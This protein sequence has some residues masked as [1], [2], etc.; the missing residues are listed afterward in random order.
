MVAALCFSYG[1]GP[2]VHE[3]RPE[4]MS[5][6]RRP[7]NDPIMAPAIAVTSSSS[8]INSG[9][10]DRRSPA[11]SLV[12]DGPDLGDAGDS[13]E[14]NRDTEEDAGIFSDEFYSHDTD[15]ETPE[16]GDDDPQTLGNGSSLFSRN[17]SN[18][19]SSDSSSNMVFLSF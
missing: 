9:V 3:G 4:I 14:T 18:N 13:P 12:S 1:D 10:D 16:R 17:R 11:E 7:F 6:D 5:N 15:D 19:R 8:E 2:G